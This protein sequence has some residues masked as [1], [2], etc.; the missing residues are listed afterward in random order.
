MKKN[1]KHTVSHTESGETEN[2]NRSITSKEIQSVIKNIAS[3]KN[4]GLDG[5]TGEFYQA[6]KEELTPILLKLFQ[7]KLKMKEYF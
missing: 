6:F 3:K 2:L 4:P 1:Q 5:F 7:K